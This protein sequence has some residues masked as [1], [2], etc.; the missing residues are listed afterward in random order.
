MA[1]LPVILTKNYKYHCR[2]A[3]GVLYSGKPRLLHPCWVW[4]FFCWF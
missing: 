4:A 2:D 3:V 1:L